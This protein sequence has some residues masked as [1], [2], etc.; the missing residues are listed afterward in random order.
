M[1]ENWK[2]R[3]KLLQLDTWKTQENNEKTIINKIMQFKKVG[4]KINTQKT[5]QLYIHKSNDVMEEK[6]QLKLSQRKRDI[7]S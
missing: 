4:Y 5:V 7:Q 2:E 1:H 3:D 6:T